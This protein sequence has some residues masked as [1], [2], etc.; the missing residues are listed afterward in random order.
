MTVF[1]FDHSW[2]VLHGR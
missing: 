1:T 2:R